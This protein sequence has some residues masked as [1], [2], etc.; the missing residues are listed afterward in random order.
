MRFLSMTYKSKERFEKMKKII[1]KRV[2]YTFEV[3]YKGEKISYS[4]VYIPIGQKNR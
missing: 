4:I 2:L 1:G 3:E